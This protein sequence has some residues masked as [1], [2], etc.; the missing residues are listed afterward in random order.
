V[1]AALEDEASVSGFLFWEPDFF[2]PIDLTVPVA[3]GPVIHEAVLEITLR[4]SAAT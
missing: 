4:H 1:K 2:G 3:S